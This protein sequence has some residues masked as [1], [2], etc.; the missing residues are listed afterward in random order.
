[1]SGGS[2]FLN[3]PQAT[4]STS[5]TCGRNRETQYNQVEVSRHIASHQPRRIL[6]PNI[7][8]GGL[9]GGMSENEGNEVATPTFI[10]T[11]GVRDSFEPL[12]PP[13]LSA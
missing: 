5:G 9:G 11:I 7:G 6:L 3:E 1:M 2:S 12:E 13:W 4:V 8:S 10:Y